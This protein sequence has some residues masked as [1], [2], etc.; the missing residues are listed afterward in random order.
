MEEFLAA[1]DTLDPDAVRGLLAPE[2]RLHMADG[3]A[4]QGREAVRDLLGAFLGTLR[5]TVH[6][7]TEQ[8]HV[9]DVW[10]AEVQARYE[11]RDHLQLTLPRVFIARHG[12]QGITDLRAYGAHERPLSEHR[13][14]EEGMWVG[15][16]WI[17][18]L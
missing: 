17:P 15:D 18:P 9:H 8:W 6:T 14:G 11:L 4:A 1:V 5:S 7:I 3:Q 16:R 12:P 2:C 10:I 13:T